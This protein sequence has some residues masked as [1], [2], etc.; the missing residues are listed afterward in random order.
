MS[1][2]LAIQ[3]LRAS[4]SYK[5]ERVVAFAKERATNIEPSNAQ[6]KYRDDLYMFLRKKGVIRDGFKLGKTRKMIHSDIRAFSTII[7]KHGLWDEWNGRG[8]VASDIMMQAQEGNN[9]R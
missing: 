1:R 3:N 8:E 2:E 4:G 7:T 5:G 9:A 6:K